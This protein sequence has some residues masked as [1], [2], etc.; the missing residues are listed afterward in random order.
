MSWQNELDSLRAGYHE[1]AGQDRRSMVMRI[2][3]MVVTAATF[4]GAVALGMRHTIVVRSN[5]PVL[6]G[7][8]CVRYDE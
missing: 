4:V 1:N 6:Q 2:A 5:L 8:H 7:V 3:A